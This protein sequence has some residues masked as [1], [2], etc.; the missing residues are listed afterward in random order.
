LHNP[1]NDLEKWKKAAKAAKAI[2]NTKWYSLDPDYSDIFNNIVSKELI[3]ARRSG[4]SNYFEDE[5]FPIGYERNALRK[6]A[7]NPTQNLVDVYEMQKTGLPTTNPNSGYD[8]HH[9][10]KGRDP[11]LKETIIVNNSTWKGRKV[12][13]WD[14]GLDGPPIS[15]ATKTGYY[16]KKY[17]IENID[18]KPNETTTANHA[19]ILFRYGGILLDYA[20]AMNEAYGPEDPADLGMT[21]RQAVDKI[22]ERSHMPDFPMGMSKAQFRKKLYN[23][24]RVEMAFEGQRFWDIRRWKTGPPTTTIKG[25]EITK[26]ADGSF[27]YHEKTVEHRVWKKKMFL[28]PISQNELYKNKNLKQNTGW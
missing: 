18:L 9:P 17:V 2:I 12:Q 6:N 27:S 14:G 7:T 10:Y 21:A 22:R 3:F 1:S 15:G 13:I 4:K 24:R 23:E 8:P 11:R 26:N 28:Y 16:L 5:N 19:W 20:E 25:M